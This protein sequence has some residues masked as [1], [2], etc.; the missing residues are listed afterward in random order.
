[1]VVEYMEEAP[2]V[3][4]IVVKDYLILYNIMT[5]VYGIY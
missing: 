3:V 1:M 4:H 2:F 5:I